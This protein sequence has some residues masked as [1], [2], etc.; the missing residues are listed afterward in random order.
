MNFTA[1][2]I[3]SYWPVGAVAI[4]LLGLLIAMVAR[5]VR[6]KDRPQVEAPAVPSGPPMTAVQR[7]AAEIER[8]AR[9]RSIATTVTAA[10]PAASLPT[11]Q[12]TWTAR[13]DPVAAPIPEAPA[14]AVPLERPAIPTSVISY[15]AYGRPAALEAPREGERDDL[16][17]IY[18]IGPRI[19][20]GLNELGVYHY[21]QIA[22]WDRRTVIW[23][24]THFSLRGKV[25]RERWVHQAR[26]LASPQG[27]MSLTVR[28]PLRAG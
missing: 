3:A 11:R 26:A 10:P 1:D 22:A 18:G 13:P 12:S 2:L 14:E 8:N 9:D 19:E 5:F 16:K 15:A 23:V 7:L 17:L 21:D 24:E 6:R 20:R 27:L 28:R 4:I 25:T